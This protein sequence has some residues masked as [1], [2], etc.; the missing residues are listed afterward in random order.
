MHS[1]RQ[2]LIAK[3]QVQKRIHEATP[4]AHELYDRF[5]YSLPMSKLYHFD[6][7]MC[8]CRHETFCMAS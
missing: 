7:R 2:D 3:M 5:L 8:Q 4:L 6:Q 1:Y